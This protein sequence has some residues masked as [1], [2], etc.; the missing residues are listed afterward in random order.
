MGLLD[1]GPGPTRTR[2]ELAKAG[3]PTTLEGGWEA[4]SDRESR[5]VLVLEA[6]LHAGPHPRPAFE[7]S[8]ER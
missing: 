4:A 7:S 5:S 6:P 3:T 2:S 1:I 8:D